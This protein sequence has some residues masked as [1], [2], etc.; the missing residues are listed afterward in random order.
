CRSPPN[1][2]G[3]GNRSSKKDRIVFTTRSKSRE[4]TPKEGMD[5]ISCPRTKVLCDAQ[6][7]IDF[8]LF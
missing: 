3:A 7:S 1:D 6:M 8:R 2:G 5:R 4:E